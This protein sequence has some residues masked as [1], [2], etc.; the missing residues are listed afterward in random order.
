MAKAISNLASIRLTAQ[1]FLD[2]KIGV[3]VVSKE[4]SRYFEYQ[5]DTDDAELNELFGTFWAVDD[6]TG[7]FPGD[8]LRHLW[9]DDALIR[10]DRRMKDFEAQ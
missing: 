4:L 5:T 6:Q 3:I 7:E 9:A 10:E 8:K 2:G 1:E